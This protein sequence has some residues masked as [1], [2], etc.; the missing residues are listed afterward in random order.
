MQRFRTGRGPAARDD[1][2]A[3]LHQ[4]MNDLR[5]TLDVTIELRV[6]RPPMYQLVVSLSIFPADDDSLALSAWRTNRG[7]SAK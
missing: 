7:S 4:Q 1:R 2:I 3:H 5:V 6:I